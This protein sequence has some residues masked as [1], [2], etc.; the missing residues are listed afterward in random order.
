MKRKA[1]YLLSSRNGRRAIYVDEE[2]YDEILNYWT[3][4]LRHKKKFRFMSEVIVEGKYTSK[5]YKKVEINKRCK[6]V[7]EM[8]FFVSEEN[9]RIYCK[10]V[11]SPTGTYIIVAAILHERKKSED[12]SATEISL[13]EKVGTYNYEL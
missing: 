2:N 9:D 7:T 10:E 11:S 6:N 1:K 13:I 5:Q 3:R 8:R 4:D 12:L